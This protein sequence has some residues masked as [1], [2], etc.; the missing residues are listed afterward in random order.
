MRQSLGA[1]CTPPNSRAFFQQTRIA[2]SGQDASRFIAAVNPG[3]AHRH[4]MDKG[5]ELVDDSSPSRPILTSAD[6]AAESCEALAL[7]RVWG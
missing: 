1:L 2:K 6:I 5:V 4:R 3:I 7:R